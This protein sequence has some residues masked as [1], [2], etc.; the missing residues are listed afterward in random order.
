LAIVVLVGGAA[1]YLFVRKPAMAPA[2]SIKVEMSDARIAR[3]RYIFTLGDCDSCHSQRDT[4]KPY[5]PVVESGRGEG[6]VFPATDMPGKVV[7]PNITPDKETGIGNWTDGEKIRAIR[8]GVDKDGKALF[9]MM[10]YEQF[11]HMSDEDVQSLVAYL[12]SLPAIRNPLPA[13]QLMFPVSLMIKGAP[14]P[15]TNPVAT[16]DKSNKQVYAEYLATIGLCEV[17]HTPFDKG[18][19]DMSKHYAGGRTFKTTFGTVVSA[20]ITPD[21]DTGIGNWSLAYFLERF[22]QKKDLAEK[23]LPA[24]EPAKFTVMPWLN[25]ASLPP[26]DLEALHLYLQGLRPVVNKVETHPVLTAEK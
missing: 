16:P 10:P 3:G 2:S 23:G 18:S 9:P 12:N 14:Q 26:E 24:A 17:C 8:E 19:F 7:V 4:T 11:R 20:N 25:L 13:T 1:G 21:K 6:K 15:V 22:S 5:M